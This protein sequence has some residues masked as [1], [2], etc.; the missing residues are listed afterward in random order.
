MK[1]TLLTSQGLAIFLMLVGL[2]LVW[3]YGRFYRVESRQS[4]GLTVRQRRILWALRA[5]VAILALLAL[6]RP[7][8]TVVKTRQRLP[9]VALLLDGSS[10]M[11][12]PDARDNSLVRKAPGDK[13]TRYDTARTV[14]DKLRDPL[15]LTHRVKIFKFSDTLRLLRELP[16]RANAR[17]AAIG[18]SELYTGAEM[19]VGDYSNIGDAASDA[20]RELAGDKVSAIVLLSDGRQTGGLDLQRAA[21]ELKQAGIPLHAVTFGSEYPLRD[22]RIDE[23]VVPP[24]ASLGDILVFNVK[25]ENQIQ[26][27]LG[28][29]ITVAEEGTPVASKQLLLKRGENQVTVTVVPENEG[30]REF[31]LALPVFEDEI[32]TANNEAVVHV[33]VVKRTLR[34]LLIASMATR[35]YFYM[36]PA[37]LR[38]PV[39]DLSCWLQVA[40]IDYVQQGN[41]NIQKLPETL[42][43]W[44]EYD[45]AILYDPDPNKLTTQQV[46]GIENMVRKGGGLLIVAGRNHGLA[47]LVQVHAVQMRNLLPVDVDK[48]L[49][50]NTSAFYEQPF[51]AERTTRGRG[52]PIML[53]SSDDRQNETLWAGFPKFYWAH[54][55]ER[56]KPNAVTLLE[57]KDAAA[58]DASSVGGDCL[59]AIQRYGEGAVFYSGINSMWLWRYPYESF[60]Y[61]RFWS[62]AIRYLGETRLTG[63]QQ[64]VSL[65]TDRQTYTPGEP[66]T[67]RLRVLDPALMAQMEG[68]PLFAT[69]TSPDKDE[70]AVPMKP[71][72]G[73]EMFYS[74]IYR[75]RRLGSM[76]VRCKQI[77]PES[78]SEGK[79]L[80]DIKHAFTVKMQSLEERDTSGNL[81]IMQQVARETGGQYFDYRNM[82]T[83]D[84][85]V[86]AIPKD[87]QMLSESR[88][89]EMWDGL[90]FLFLFL[91]LIAAEWCFRKAWGLL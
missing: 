17:E 51:T 60:D 28:T 29:T 45:V 87:M 84:E 47:K 43:E 1:P 52:H 44:A 33:K 46:T 82:Q 15:S 83:V 11:A 61:D 48:N 38:D 2:V 21:T 72:P 32:N 76:I 42:A 56:P 8:M 9:V 64:Q 58:P 74:G 70:Q 55:V 5:G 36:V 18:S 78:D 90:F 23:V 39:L 91:A 34:V 14:A 27:R 89:V 16:H 25:V 85:L 13:R 19:P 81:E 86:S 49:M 79:A 24:E 71:D 77:A 88:M 3:L 6:A 63:T 30:V 37:L 80:F 54:P 59:M 22:L 69:V 65:D 35:E 4:R 31:R 10:S 66:V 75:A 68:L 12:F 41:K 62:R 26:E 53:A 20:L 67:I 57:K 40:D 50:P 7:A 73:G